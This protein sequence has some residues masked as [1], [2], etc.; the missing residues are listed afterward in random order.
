MFH[1]IWVILF[2]IKL[3]KSV[4]KAPKITFYQFNQSFVFINLTDP[5]PIFLFKEIQFIKPHSTPNLYYRTVY[6]VS[7]SCTKWLWFL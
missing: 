3:Y 2:I 7:K 6:P 1:I 5:H 4:A